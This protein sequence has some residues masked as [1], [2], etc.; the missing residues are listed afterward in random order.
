MSPRTTPLPGDTT[1]GVA[2]LTGNA[3]GLVQS[4]RAV[5][6]PGSSAQ[7]T[8]CPI[9]SLTALSWAERLQYLYFRNS[10]TFPV[11]P[12]QIH[13]LQTPPFLHHSTPQKCYTISKQAPAH[14]DIFLLVI[15]SFIAK[16]GSTLA[17]S[18]TVARQATLSMGFPR[19]EYCNGL[20]FSSPRDLSNPG[21]E[22]GSPELQADYLLT[23]PPGKPRFLLPSYVK[24]LFGG[25]K[26]LLSSDIAT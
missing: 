14:Q 19:Q 10:D 11:A 15:G 24:P 22:L 4:L 5:R 20:P 9:S 13:Q 12:C 2:P 25:K 17:T 7:P 3:H 1:H 16:S 18:W 23:E 8:Q 6:R 26:R 21:I